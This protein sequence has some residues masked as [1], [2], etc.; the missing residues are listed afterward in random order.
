M[1]ERATI[2]QL[3]QI[4][5]ESAHG[6]AVAASK[7]LEC[8]SFNF[9]IEAVVDFFRA[10]GRKYPS[11]AEENQE[12]TSFTMDGNADY[13]GLIYP[14]SGVAGTATVAAY[15]SSATA[16]GW[17]YIPPISGNASPKTFTFE[18][19]DS[20]RAHKLAYGLF[21]KFGY[22]GDRKSLMCSAEGMGQLLSDGITLTTS[23]T[24]IALAPA[25]GKHVN[26]YLDSTSGG[27]GTT[28]L[29]RVLSYE[30]S[31]DSVYGPGWFVNRSDTS[32]STHIDMEPKSTFKLMVEADSNGMAFLDSYLRSGA[33]AYIRVEAQGPVIASDGGGGSDDVYTL[34]Q[35]DM[36]VKFDKPDKWAD[37]DGV[38]AIQWNTQ[39]VDDLSWG[40]GQAQEFLLVNLLSAL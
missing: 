24:G 14:L 2:N 6:T 15:N 13:N 20:V 4:G 22:K 32:W 19:G 3:T 36:A 12:W 7:T 35:H 8:F 29:T 26:I 10:T 37:S 34:F 17:T 16:K 38:F 1:A 33:T 23:P 21:N 39:V 25:T 11:V 27:L 9:G 18:Q 31:M 5:V 28:Q 40:S 30:F